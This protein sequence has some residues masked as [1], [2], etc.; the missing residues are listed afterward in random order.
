MP[1][2]E[3]RTSGLLQA[4]VA[5]LVVGWMFRDVPATE[6]ART[7]PY[8]VAGYGALAATVPWLAGG[9]GRDEFALPYSLLLGVLFAAPMAAAA[10]WLADSPYRAIHAGAWGL[11]AAW[12]VHLLVAVAL[13]RG[14][15]RKG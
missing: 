6:P 8:V 7:W 13:R 15:R 2:N 3:L 14:A 10:A 4:A 9:V 12:G 11:V 1:R 5:A